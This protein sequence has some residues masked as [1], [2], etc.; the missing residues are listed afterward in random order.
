VLLRYSIS[1]ADRSRQIRDELAG[2]YIEQTEFYR[3]CARA[4][5]TETA[6]AEH[7]KR[8]K[9]ILELFA[10]FDGLRKAA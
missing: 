7:E 5:P 6:R 2:L 4:K 8:R 9:R 1:P 3:D 10:E